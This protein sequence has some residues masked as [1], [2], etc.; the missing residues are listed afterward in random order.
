MT[1]PSG[2]VY[3]LNKNFWSFAR[4]L[5]LN[6]LSGFHFFHIWCPCRRRFHFARSWGVA[7]V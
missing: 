6:C 7:L 2:R 5:I 3:I 1:L 4:M